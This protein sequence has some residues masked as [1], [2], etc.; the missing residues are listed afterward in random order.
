LRALAAL[1]R[2]AVAVIVDTVAEFRRSR[3]DRWVAVIAVPADGRVTRWR[4]GRPYA[5][6]VRYRS[7]VTVPIGVRIIVHAAL[8]RDAIAVIVD[9][10]VADFS[11]SRM[12]CRVAVIAIAVV[13]RVT[14]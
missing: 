3:M 4:R 11:R 9:L 13:R 8:I 7:S 6:D 10:V 5:R 14:R 12:N 1:V 2:N